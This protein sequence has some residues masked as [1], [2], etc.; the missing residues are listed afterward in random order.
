MRELREDEKVWE[1]VY[2]PEE[3]QNYCVMCNA[4]IEA[5]KLCEECAKDNKSPDSDNHENL[6]RTEI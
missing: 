3:S 5:Y 2:S 6:P 1:D 4:K